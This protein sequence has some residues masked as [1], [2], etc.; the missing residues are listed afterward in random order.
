MI[1]GTELIRVVQE[2]T[3][4]IR[5]S[6]DGIDKLAAAIVSKTMSRTEASILAHQLIGRIMSVLRELDE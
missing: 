5:K 2:K 4:T 1:E 3:S 6:C